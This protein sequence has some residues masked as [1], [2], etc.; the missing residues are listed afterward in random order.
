MPYCSSCGSQVNDNEKFCANCGA[1]IE[2]NTE[3]TSEVKEEIKEEVKWETSYEDYQPE[4]VLESGP[5]AKDKLAKIGATLGILGFVFSFIP[6][7]NMFGC[8]LALIGLIFGIIGKK[9]AATEEGKAKARKAFSFGLAG[10]LISIVT[11]Y[12]YT[13]IFGVLE[14]MLLSL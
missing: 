11:I 3:T 10:L 13:F 7:L 8:D 5:N 12:I 4:E 2:S 14:S 9:G 1:L 6:L